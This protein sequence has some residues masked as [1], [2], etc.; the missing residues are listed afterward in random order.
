[1]PKEN[2]K[3]YLA[4]IAVIA[5]VVLVIAFWIFMNGSSYTLLKQGAVFTLTPGI[6]ATYN[7]SVPQGKVGVLSG[8]YSVW[9]LNNTYTPQVAI[10]T[11][12][13]TQKQFAAFVMN[14]KN[15]TSLSQINSTYYSGYKE[16]V[17]LNLRL[18]NGTYTLVF[19]NPGPYHDQ[20]LTN[21]NFHLVYVTK[22][23]NISY[24]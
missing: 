23:I 22:A 6:A 4:I 15:I 12:V 21:K 20:N 10:E 5:I 9:Y 17:T 11:A 19:F 13:L 8:S 18:Q 2:I 14:L 7:V 1:M 16:N 24:I 3:L